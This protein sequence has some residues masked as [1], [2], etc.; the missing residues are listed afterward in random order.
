MSTSNWIE[1]GLLV[2]GQLRRELVKAGIAFTETKT[3]TRSV[4]VIP[5]DSDFA[6]VRRALQRQ[7]L[8]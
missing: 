6:Q 7:G 4:F 2:R 8:I 1:A 3:L 5:S